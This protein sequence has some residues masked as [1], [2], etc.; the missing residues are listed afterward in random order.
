MSPYAFWVAIYFPFLQLSE[1]IQNFDDRTCV[2]NNSDQILN[3]CFCFHH[4]WGLVGVKWNTA[5]QLVRKKLEYLPHFLNPHLTPTAIFHLYFFCSHIARL[6]QKLESWL[7]RLWQVYSVFIIKLVRAF[8]T[9]Q[10]WCL[11]EVVEKRKK[12]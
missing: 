5:L 7:I 8:V 10:N 4:N 12:A 6:L 2:S 9:R 3:F 1:S 11:F